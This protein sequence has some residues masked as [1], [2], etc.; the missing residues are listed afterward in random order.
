MGWLPG[1]W[2]TEGERQKG[3]GRGWLEER[4]WWTADGQI[5]GWVDGEAGGSR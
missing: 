2:V 5:G 1:G 4:D 3:E